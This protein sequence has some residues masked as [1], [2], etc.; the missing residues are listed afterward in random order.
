MS[1]VTNLWNVNGQILPLPGV[2]VQIH[3]T[4]CSVLC[5]SP[6]DGNCVCARAHWDHS[7]RARARA[8][9]LS[10]RVTTHSYISHAG[11]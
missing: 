11:H 8:R 2:L 5:T 4:R 7:R 9:G 3:E 6:D 1:R 10:G